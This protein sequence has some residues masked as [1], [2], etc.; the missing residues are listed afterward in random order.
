L[1]L[2]RFPNSSIVLC[3]QVFD[4]RN[5]L[6]P[7]SSV[8]PYGP[9]ELLAWNPL[10]PLSLMIG[11][12]SGMF[13]FMDTANPTTPEPYQV[14][15]P[16]QLQP[17]FVLVIIVVGRVM[18]VWGLSMCIWGGGGQG[19]LDPLSLMIG[20]SSGMFAFMNTANPTT[21]EP[22]QVNH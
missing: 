15:T 19:P 2:A 16:Y 12:S 10:D 14:R 4:A 22:Y 6:R 8:M 20:S 1:F 17:K 11:S 5:M 13:A 21:P 3:M 7:L 9:A 18:S